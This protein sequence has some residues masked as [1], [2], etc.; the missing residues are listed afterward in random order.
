MCLILIALAGLISI[1]S[2]AH[3]NVPRTLDDIWEE[4]FNDPIHVP[5]ATRRE[6]SHV[7][8]TRMR[9]RDTVQVTD[10]NTGRVDYYQLR[11]PVYSDSNM[12]N[13]Y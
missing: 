11:E 7:Y 13:D 2:K 5:K 4:N 3:A 1:A 10:R 8:E 6:P 9:T 12:Y